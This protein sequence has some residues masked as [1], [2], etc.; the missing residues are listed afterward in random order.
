M[1]KV[2]GEAMAWSLINF[3]EEGIVWWFG[4]IEQLITDRGSM[5]NSREFAEFLNNHR[6]RHRPMTTYHQQSH[7]LVKQM[8]QTLKTMLKQ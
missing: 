3:V 4:A 8:A 5:M 7:G 1:A 6:I 2:V